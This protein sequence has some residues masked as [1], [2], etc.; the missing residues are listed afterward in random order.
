MQKLSTSQQAIYDF[1]K[2]YQLKNGYPPSVREICTAVGLSSTSTVHGHLTRLQRKGLLK[3]DP[4]KPRAI[5]IVELQKNRASAKAL[6]IIGTVTAGTPILA[7]EYIEG[8]MTVGDDFAR[9]ENLFILKVKG[10]SMIGA[11][12]MHGDQIVVNPDTY[13][14]NG[15][16]VVAMLNEPSTD[17]TFA[18]V[19]RFFKENNLVRLQ[20]E[21]PNMEPIFTNHVEIVGKVVGVMRKIY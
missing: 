21:N 2:E 1:M 10:E 14:K 13:I 20:P 19:K 6:P 7:Q 9:G 16:I 12:I 3:R 8:Y 17:E 5:Q 18:T 11:G 15:D 4:S